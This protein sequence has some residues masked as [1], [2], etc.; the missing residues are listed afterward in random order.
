MERIFVTSVHF[1]EQQRKD[2][3]PGDYNK[4]AE[5]DEGSPSHIVHLK[6]QACTLGCDLANNHK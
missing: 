2:S 5:Q 1:L 6:G 3:L 4:R